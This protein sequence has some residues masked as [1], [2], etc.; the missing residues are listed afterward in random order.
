[1]SRGKPKPVLSEKLYRYRSSYS[2][3]QQVKYI[4]HLDMT[5]ALPR[6]FRRA[7]IKL[8]YSHGFHPMPLIQYGPAL[9]VGCEGENELLEFHSPDRLTESDF[10]MRL[11]PVLPAGLQFRS[12]DLLPAE[13]PSLTK[14]ISRAEYIVGLDAVEIA[15]A[16]SRLSSHGYEL[17][18][19]D[20]LDLHNS[21]VDRFLARDSYVIVRAHKAKRQN[22]D[23]R[24]FTISLEVDVVSFLL[25]LVTLI[26]PNGGVKPVEVLAAVYDLAD[27]EKLSLN[28]RIKRTRLYSGDSSAS[29]GDWIAPGRLQ[30]G[31]QV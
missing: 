29:D 27:D 21:L 30:Q 2:K 31:A 9:G 18:R 8:G 25:R 6:A 19:T 14:L 13:D 17:S 7:R 28:S 1:V 12:L 20:T 24:R 22:I 26:S 10:L 16:L 5:R 11:N 23:V 3:M 4:S 15:G